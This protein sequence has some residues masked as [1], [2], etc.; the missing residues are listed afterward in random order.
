MQLYCPNCRRARPLGLRCPECDT[1]LVAAAEAHDAA[2]TGRVA[3]PP[4]PP[5]ASAVGRILAG[6]VAALGTVVALRDLALGALGLVAGAEAASEAAPA[7]GVTFATV[8]AMV[9]GLLAGAGLRH[10]ALGGGFAGACVGILLTCASSQ[11]GDRGPLGV[12]DVAVAC[13]LAAV[14]AIAGRVGGH[15]WPP[16]PPLPVPPM[17]TRGSSVARLVEAAAADTPVGPPTR[18]GRIAVGA[19]VL[20][21]GVHKAGDLTDLFGQTSLGRMHLTAARPGAIEAALALVTA[22]LGGVVAG[23][24]THAGWRHG[25]YAGLAGAAGVGLLAATGNSAVS[26]PV[27]GL[28]DVLGRPPGGL[29]VAGLLLVVVATAGGA[30]GAALLPVLGKR[31]KLRLMD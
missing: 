14:A 2:L 21:V 3:P 9:G 19:V 29:L 20:A 26:V 22:A 23:A 18:W 12:Q 28:V 16:A 25:L 27:E 13:G 5:A 4:P 8:G 31:R 15:V 10:G 1:R 30:F 6:V 17:K 11:S 24:V 7:L